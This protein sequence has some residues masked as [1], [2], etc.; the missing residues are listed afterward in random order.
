MGGK[1][2]KKI[3]IVTGSC[4]R[5]GTQVVKKLGETFS[6]VGFELSKTICSSPN[7]QLVAVDVSSEKSIS[8]GLT[9]VRH[10][11]GTKIASV[12]H[13][14]AYYS[15]SE[16]HSDKYDLITVQ[17]TQKLLDALQ[18]F[19]VEQFI[20][21]STM[22]VH[23]PTKPGYPITEHS[24]IVPKWDYP[25]SKVKTEKII[26][27]FRGN[28]PTV[29]LRV[30]GVYDDFCHSIPISHQIQ[31]IYEKQLEARLFAGNTH[32]GAA[33]VH[34]DDLVHAIKLAVD[35]RKELPQETVLLIGE[36]KTMSYD[37]MQKSI[38]YLLFHKKIHTY[39][40]PKWI[41]KIG[42]WFLCHI[43]FKDKPFIRPWMIDLADDHYE[44]NIDLAK[45]MLGWAPKYSIEKTLPKMIDALLK[46]PAAW[47][48]GNQLKM[49]C[50]VAHEK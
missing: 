5:I 42:S 39:S 20:F 15:F 38:S 27:K 11:Y 45:Q 9:H 49:S 17:G 34:M 47:Y 31:R 18:D 28:I 44:M 12:I 32:H 50:K 37:A 14:A 10:F 19:E 1:M 29:I 23:A 48:Q 3:I 40:I 4:G 36:P 16:Q 24:P 30:A 41:A 43:P 13:L 33:F 26:H 25:L 46:D 6:I 35:K 2:E 7:E 8:E 21:T 22:L